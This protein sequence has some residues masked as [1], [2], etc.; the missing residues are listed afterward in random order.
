MLFFFAES[1][2]IWASILITFIVVTIVALIFSLFVYKKIR[3]E[4]VRFTACLW[5]HHF[6]DCNII[7]RS[8]MTIGGRLPTKTF[9]FPIRQS[10]ATSR[11]CLWHSLKRM[12]TNRG[13]HLLSRLVAPLG[14]RLS[15]LPESSIRW[16]LAYT[17][18]SKL[19]SSLSISND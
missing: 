7:S 14:T 15:A 8:W 17:E 13:R 1:F 2:P 10:L 16:M 19:H 9:Y 6:Q 18:A 4:Q 11:P 3:L 12:A 5:E